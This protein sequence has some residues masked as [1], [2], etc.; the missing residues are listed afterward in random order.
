[1]TTPIRLDYSLESPEER[2]ILVAEIIATI[3]SSQLTSRYKEILANYIIFA[4]DKEDR[5]QKR[6]LTDN[7]MVTVNKRETSYEALVDKLENG[8]DG[9]YNLMREDKNTL[10]SPKAPI[11]EQDIA[12]IPH[13]ASLVEVISRMEP[14]AK[15]AIGTGKRA[16]LL[17]RGVIQMR[18]DQYVARNGAKQPAKA[19]S[20][21]KSLAKTAL[22]ETVYLDENQE[23]K[24]DGFINLYNP[25]HV[26]A[27]LVHYSALKQEVWDDLGAD[28]HFLLIDLDNMVIRALA[29][30]YPMLFDLALYKIDGSTNL[31]IQERLDADYSI[32]HSVEYLS[33]LWRN[34]IPKLIA[35]K[36]QE[37]W[38]LWHFTFE[39][40]GKWKRCSR[41]GEI[42]L[43]HNKFFSKNKTS[44]DGFYSVCKC[45]RN[46]KK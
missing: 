1:M 46:K 27:L 9:I 39:E 45:C 43:A 31:E 35:E 10:L 36:S 3:P 41:C 18:Q 6:I 21:V 22:P 33:S 12:D 24:S 25:H 28:M 26:E 38:L 16:F 44:K 29:E 40:V 42:K 20:L 32:K 15:A 2:T 4:S 23:V 17:R 7:R 5:K 30:D 37:D 11:T 8:E 19:N 34:K 14:M 13:L